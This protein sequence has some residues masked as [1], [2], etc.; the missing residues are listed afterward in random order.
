MNKVWDWWVS[1]PMS[2]A[3]SVLIGI[4]V[5]AAVLGVVLPVKEES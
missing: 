1:L 5:V 4:L 2:D 3:T